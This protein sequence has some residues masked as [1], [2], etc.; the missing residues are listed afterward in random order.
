L[1]DEKDR[2]LIKSDG[3]YT[4]F[5]VDIVYHDSK[6]KRGFTHLINIWGADHHGYVARVKAAISALNTTKNKPITFSVIIGQLVHLIRDGAPVRMSKRTGDMISLEEVIDEIGSDAT[7]YF[8]IEHRADTHLEFD[9]DLAKKQSSENP[10]YYIQYA[11]ARL[12][13]IFKK[14]EVS[15][16]INCS[17]ELS[18][19]V[20][21]E[22]HLI[23][24]LAQWPEEAWSAACQQQPYQI[25]QYCLK[26]ARLFHAFYEKC[27]IANTDPKT[28][29]QRLSILV[30]VQEVLQKALSILGISAPETM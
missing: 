19:L 17:D 3:S 9:L 26:L 30:K 21:A 15:L 25:A 22:R 16:P 24:F 13:R 8:L 4:Y 11:H 28:Q 6:L 1:G 14:L 18:S 10:V 23:F 7:R 20:P 12:C 29:H 27:P 2:V 5:A